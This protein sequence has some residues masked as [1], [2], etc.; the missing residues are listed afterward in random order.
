MQ[1][2]FLGAAGTVT[3]SKYLVETAGQRFLVDCGLFQG[4]KPFRLKNRE[5]LPVDPKSIG[6]VVLTH[7][8]LD[9]SGYLPLLVRN[10]FTG[11][12]FC[13]TAT[14]RLCRILLPDSGKL[15]EEEAL[16]ANQ[17]GFSKH[18]P[19]L[20]L[21]TMDDA[22]KCL[23][24]FA[25]ISFHQSFQ[26]SK[27]VSAKF[28]PAGHILGAASVQLR[29]EDKT[30]VFSGDLGRQHDLV[31][32]PPELISQADVLVVESTYGAKFH[33]SLDPL[34][35]LEAIAHRTFQRGGI[36]VAPSFAVGRAQSLLYVIYLLKKAKRIP[37]V[38]VFL[39]SPMAID[40]TEVFCAFQDEH[41]LSAEE[42]SKTFAGVKYVH[43]TKES[44][45]L[46]EMRKPMILIAGS[47]MATGG[48]ILHHLSAFGPDRRNTI[49]FT[50]FQ[51]TGTRGEAL[52]HGAKT[53]K[54]HGQTISIA[55]E[56][57]RIDT[58]SAHADQ[59]EILK[60]LAGFEA[61]PQKTFITHG[62]PESSITLAKVI[63]EKLGWSCRAPG[64]MEQVEI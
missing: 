14:E 1:L 50:G 7:A 20:A 33:G 56:V 41:R 19:A 60:W 52:I 4:L 2:T 22:E 57:A 35:Q 13:T 48:R 51:A 12:I 11:K 59:G 39:D 61:P 3:G 28:I 26:V 62:E 40:A 49:L 9:H 24:N 55:A 21:Y 58:L 15:Q 42:C 23:R 17:K 46:I 63:E 34:D 5:A 47:G 44:K 27:N 10:G 38:P 37:D 45:S 43:D 16:Y 31:M 29:I 30:V 18:H 25:P 8:H 6:A 32:R 64:P 53:V 36:V 54:I